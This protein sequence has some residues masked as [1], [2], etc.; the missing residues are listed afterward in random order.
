M[1]RFFATGTSSEHLSLLQSSMERLLR[2]RIHLAVVSL[3]N[4]APRNNYLVPQIYFKCHSLALCATQRPPPPRG[5]APATLKGTILWKIQ[6]KLVLL[7]LKLQYK[8][9][10]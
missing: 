7:Q 3:G 4:N 2:S 8:F 10:V 1:S 9:Q 5:S 6:A